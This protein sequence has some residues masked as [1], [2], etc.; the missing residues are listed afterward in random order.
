MI[1]MPDFMEQ[2]INFSL[3]SQVMPFLPAFHG[4]LRPKQPPQ[5]LW[6]R[7]EINQHTQDKQ[8][9]NAARQ[10]GHVKPRLQERQQ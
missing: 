5:F 2:P 10:C 8:G 7:R 3:V 9:E 1:A 4:L 6:Q